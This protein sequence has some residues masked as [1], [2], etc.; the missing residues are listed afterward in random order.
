MKLIFALR[1][2]RIGDGDDDALGNHLRRQLREGEENGFHRHEGRFLQRQRFAD[3]RLLRRLRLRLGGLGKLGGSDHALRCGDGSI[4][5]LR[6]GQAGYGCRRY[7]RRLLRQNFF[8]LTSEQQ[9]AD[10][11]R[12]RQCA[13]RHIFQP[14]AFWLRRAHDGRI[15]RLLTILTRDLVVNQRIANL[16]GDEL[17]RV[18]VGNALR[19]IQPQRQPRRQ[20][21]DAIQINRNHLDFV[22]QRELNLRPH[23]L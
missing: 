22:V 10:D 11:N 15:D 4:P 23:I 20:H 19:R 13:A 5:A 8:R 7:S 18:D 14:R 1:V 6:R 16:V 3:G 12:R 17:R 9:H 2:A 21:I